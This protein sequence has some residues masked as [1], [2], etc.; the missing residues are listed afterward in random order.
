MPLAVG[1][2]NSN[3]KFSMSRYTLEYTPAVTSRL[4]NGNCIFKLLKWKGLF[5]EVIGTKVTWSDTVPIIA[6]KR[7]LTHVTIRA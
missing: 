5:N 3:N 1:H 4:I 2:M 7:E 6:D